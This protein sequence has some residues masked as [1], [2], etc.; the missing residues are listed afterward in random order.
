MSNAV[1]PPK[2]EQPKYNI[3]DSP[4][5]ESF[6][7]QKAYN[8][9]MKKFEEEIEDLHTQLKKKQNKKSVKE[10]IKPPRKGTVAYN[11]MMKRKEQEKDPER[12]KQIEKLGDDDNMYGIAKIKKVRESSGPNGMNLGKPQPE[13]VPAKDT[14]WGFRKSAPKKKEVEEGLA[15]DILAAAKKVVPSAKIVTPE[16]KRKEREELDVKRAADRKAAPAKTPAKADPDAGFGQNRG[17]GQGRYMGDDVEISTYAKMFLE[18]L[19]APKVQEAVSYTDFDDWKAAVLNS[20]PAQAKKIKFK[21]RMEGNKD[22][23]SAEV[24]GEDRSYGVW[25]QDE[26]KGVVLSEMTK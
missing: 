25:S 19:I 13:A 10:D 4:Y 22:T 24:P 12:I 7:V 8:E 11:A 9:M 21:G 6:D 5:I 2:L 26:E 18:K 15:D 23:I 14:R 20:Y 1:K 17:Y 16:Q 3:F